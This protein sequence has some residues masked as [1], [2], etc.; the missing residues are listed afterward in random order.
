MGTVLSGDPAH[1]V[2][3]VLYT[4]FLIPDIGFSS[5]RRREACL[6]L[7]VVYHNFENDYGNIIWLAR[8]RSWTLGRHQMSRGVK[9]IA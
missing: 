4:A 1:L 3:C 7:G 6:V 5:C 2:A 8:S 9:K